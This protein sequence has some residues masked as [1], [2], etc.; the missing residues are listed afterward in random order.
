MIYDVHDIEHPL[1][2]GLCYDENH[3]VYGWSD[4]DHTVYFSGCFH[5]KVMSIHI[6]AEKDSRVSLRDAVEDFC[7]S[8]FNAY[9]DCVA[10]VGAIKPQ[11][12]INLAK[13]CGFEYL[14]HV[15]TE[16]GDTL[17]VYARFKK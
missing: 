15:E 1:S 9:T 5:G 7:E 3:R 13:K 6:A 8:I 10:I 12:V 11:S 4:G 16:S 17:P 14:V 2:L